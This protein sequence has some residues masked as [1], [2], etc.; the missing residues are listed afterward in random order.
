MP[1]FISNLIQDKK[2]Y[3]QFLKDV[4]ALPAPYAQTLMAI[5]K[6]LWNF[7]RSGSII[8]PLE[9]ILHL[10]Q[11][12]AAE[13]VPVQQII[14]SDPVAFAEDIMVQYPEALWLIKYQN[15]LRQQVKE[16]EQL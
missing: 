12:S 14:G 2:R 7:A 13:N 9:E 3:K 6:Y 15:Q 8:E 11:E 1:D 16:A 10:F 4:N 5:Q